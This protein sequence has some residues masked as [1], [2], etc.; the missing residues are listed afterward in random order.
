MKSDRDGVCVRVSP[1]GK[2]TDSLRY[3]YN[4]KQTTADIGTYPL[5]TL[6]EARTENQRLRKKLEQRHD[7]KGVRQLERQAMIAAKS[8]EGLYDLGTKAIASKTR[9]A[10]L[11]SGGAFLKSGGALKF[12]Y[13]E[14]E[15][16]ATCL[17]IRSAFI[18]G[19]SYL[20]G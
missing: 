18:H 8:L 14:K 2:I 5:M 6:E 1:K 7:P 17:P 16:L 4:V 12:M 20:S 9:K 3:Y 19:L 10:I 15:A 13:S 11:K